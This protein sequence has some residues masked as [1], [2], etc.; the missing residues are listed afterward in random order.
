MKQ[1]R[2]LIL[3][4]FG[5]ILFGASISIEAAKTK[6]SPGCTSGKTCTFFVDYDWCEIQSSC[7]QTCSMYSYRCCHKQ[8][9]SCIDNELTG[10]LAFVTTFAA[11]RTSRK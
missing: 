11:D 9:G 8:T 6:A 5:L 10:F 4:V 1:F 2:Y 3:F 7:S